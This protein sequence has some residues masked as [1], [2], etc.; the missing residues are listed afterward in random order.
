[1]KLAIKGHS[2]RGKEVIE[3]LE[4]MGGINPFINNGYVIGNKESHCYYISENATLKYISWDYIG[5]EEINEYMIFTLEEFEQKFPYKVGDKV[6]YIN[7]I[8]CIKS[9]QWN[10][11]RNTVIYYINADWSAGC[12]V[13]TNDLQPYKEETTEEINIDKIGFNGDKARLILP[14]G[15]ES[16]VE[17]NEVFVIKKKS[18]YSKTYIECAKILERFST[19]YIDGYKNALLEKLQELLICRDAY[20]KI[21]GDEMGLDKPWEP[22]WTN[23]EQEKH[24]IWVDV[25]SII[26]QNGYRCQHILV[27]PTEEMRYAFFENFKDLIEQC[28]ELL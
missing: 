5:P 11:E 28:K 15:Y 25:G 12:V 18:K 21:A 7:N 19:T 3:L 23:L 14:D 24:C 22:D 26:L 4:M 13:E 20:W 16:K 9:L 27:F 8:F 6:K 2:T 17:G 10:N 1:M